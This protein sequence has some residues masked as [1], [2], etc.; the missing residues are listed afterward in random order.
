MEILGLAF[1]ETATKLVLD[2]ALEADGAAS[3]DAIERPPSPDGGVG[4]R[5][6]RRAS[7]TAFD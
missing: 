1:F 5:P 3:Q 4:G 2:D 7:Y 6:S